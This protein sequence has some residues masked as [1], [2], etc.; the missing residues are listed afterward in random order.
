MTDFVF[1]DSG[2]G[3]I[4]YMTTLIKRAPEANCVYIADAANFPYG[5]KSHEEVVECVTV[6]VQKICDKM[7]IDPENIPDDTIPVYVPDRFYESHPHRYYVYLLCRHPTLCYHE[8][9]LS[10]LVYGH[11][12]NS[13]NMSVRMF[14]DIYE[15][16]SHLQVLWFYA[17]HLSP[18]RCAVT[19]SKYVVKIV[20]ECIV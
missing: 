17:L 20:T 2:I 16:V 3:G 19:I 4:P 5:E 7:K 11:I 6:L 10:L 1:I 15:A 12:N 8:Y 13:N 18:H 9:L 14:I